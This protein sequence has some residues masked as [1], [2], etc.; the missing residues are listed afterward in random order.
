MFEQDSC[1][2]DIFFNPNA[3][4]SNLNLLKLSCNYSEV[5]VNTTPEPL[6]SFLYLPLEYS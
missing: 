2:Y 1:I 6:Q 5:Q 4:L 3:N